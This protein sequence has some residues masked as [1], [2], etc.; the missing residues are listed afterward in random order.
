MPLYIRRLPCSVSTIVDASSVP[1]NHVLFNPS[2]AHPFMY[3]R[4]TEHFATKEINFALLYDIKTKN[5]YKVESPMEMLAPTVNLFQGI[6]DL[7]ICWGNDEKLWFSGTT[8]HASS[9]MTNE[10]IVGHFDTVLSRVEYMSPVDIGSLPVKNVCPFVWKNQLHLLD[11]F[12]HHIFSLNKVEGVM[13]ATLVKTLRPAAGM[14]K[15]G[16]RGSTSPVHIHGNIWGCVVHDI[17]FNDNTKLVTRLSYIHHWMEFDIETGDVTFLST[18]FWVAHWGIEYVSGIHYEKDTH[19][20]T[21]YL[22][23][24]DR[25]PLM[26]KT[27]LHDLRVGK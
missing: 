2:F 23:V 27:T 8:T 24:S 19:A 5:N 14:A 15:E 10:L 9:H 17:I 11:T 21:L 25:T 18:P 13:E 12:K 26:A 20:V 22:G 3:I 1:K 7:R 4:C 16:L 6:E